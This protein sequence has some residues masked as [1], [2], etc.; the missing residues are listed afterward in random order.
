MA[1]AIVVGA[2]VPAWGNGEEINGFP[3]WEER[4]MHEW[5][6][7]ARCDPQVEMT[8]CGSACGDAACYTPQPPLP[9]S[10][11]LNHSARFHS[12]EMAAQGYFAHDSACTL[13]SNIDS[14]YPGS[15]TGAASCACVG[16]TQ[17]CNTTCTTWN[18][19]V[20]LFGGSPAGE[21]IAS[22]TDPDSSFYQ[23]LFESYPSSA[24]GYAQ[25]PP[26]NGHRY[27]IL[28]SG[29][30]VGYGHGAGASVGDFGQGGTLD[31]IA[32]GS[33]YPRQG[34]KV[35]FWANWNDSAA[36]ASAQ[37]DVDGTCTAMTRMRGSDT[38]GAW[39]VALTTVASGCHRYVFVFTD[40]TGAQVLY[41]STGSLGVGPEGSC[42]DYATTAPAL[43][44]GGG[45]GGGGG[46]RDA[47][48]GTSNDA[49][50]GCCDTNGSAG[51]SA[52]L[53]VC[54]CYLARRRRRT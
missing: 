42:A 29:P 28:M 11:K 49:S 23:W 13:V 34:A 18:A 30:G 37:L 15:C 43:C 36:P 41:P 44:N 10:E 47:G 5:T 52:L 25:G 53:T 32:S 38:N 40:S 54:I 8:A 17:T 22:G 12:D 48:T 50:G 46:G 21:I 24:C 20:A 4:V 33:H 45:G 35:D 31:K 3:N 6:N 19:R 1:I 7:R 26:T 2:A 9:W 14:L 39:H 16:G 51:S 27:N